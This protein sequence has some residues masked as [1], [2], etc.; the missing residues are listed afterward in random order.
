MCQ[1]S[2][3]VHWPLVGALKKIQGHAT[4]QLQVSK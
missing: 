3:A 2:I 1:A 4:A